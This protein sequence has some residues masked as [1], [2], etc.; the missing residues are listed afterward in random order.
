MKVRVTLHSG[1]KLQNLP[2]FH[3]Y[4]AE[5]ARGGPDEE[6]KLVDQIQFSWGQKVEPKAESGVVPQRTEEPSVRTDPRLFT[7]TN[8][9]MWPEHFRHLR[10]SSDD[11]K[12]PKSRPDSKTLPRSGVRRITPIE[13]WN[14]ENPIVD[15]PLSK[16]RRD[17]PFKE[18]AMLVVVRST[19]LG[20]E[21]ATSMEESPVCTIGFRNRSLIFSPPLTKTGYKLDTWNGPLTAT[22]TVLDEEFTDILQESPAGE[23]ENLSEESFYL[24]TGQLV[25]YTYFVELS[26]A[27]NFPRDPLFVE[28]SVKFPAHLR[29]EPNDMMSD[30][31]LADDDP[32][33]GT[34]HG[35]SAN[36]FAN[37]RG[38]NR[39]AVLNH[40][41]EVS[42]SYDPT[43]AMTTD[44]SVW[45][46]T[47]M[48]RVMSRDFWGRSFS[49]GYGS[50]QLPVQG[51]THRL[52]VPIW[53]LKSGSDN[54]AQLREL[55]VGDP[56]SLTD[57]F[58]TMALN[59]SSRAGLD[60]EGAGSLIVN[61]SRLVQSRAFVSSEMMNR[62]K[63]GSRLN[64]IGLDSSLHWRIM[65]VLMEFEEARRELLRIRA[66]HKDQSF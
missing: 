33:I 8:K 13:A 23:M 60:T 65:K 35:T 12:T 38:R 50:I 10:P 25:Q 19:A 53:R 46:P 54:F 66:K 11:E 1:S 16:E 36:A 2:S 18:E 17:I 34:V 42:F 6:N 31:I 7:L 29:K 43:M 28:Y 49:L 55:L 57:Y 44:H 62:L 45:W 14:R 30:K 59:G 26:E 41:F 5:N 52:E 15:L 39:V 48:F 37:R 32:R 24:P 4:V 61:V 58:G 56:I 22:V 40:L 64:K 63:Y 47:I 3:E 51:N 27:I 21:R 9:E 20:S